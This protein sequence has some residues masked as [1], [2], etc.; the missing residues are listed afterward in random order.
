[1]KS[2]GIENPEPIVKKMKYNFAKRFGGMRFTHPTLEE[3]NRS[4]RDLEIRKLFREGKTYEECSKDF[5]LSISQIRRITDKKRELKLYFLTPDERLEYQI[6]FKRAK[7]NMIN[8]LYAW[9]TEG[10]PEA[11]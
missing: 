8:K 3:Y 1:L 10:E 9:L 4:K 5:N 7:E 6:E 2:F 11:R